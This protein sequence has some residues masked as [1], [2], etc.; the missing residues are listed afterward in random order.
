MCV[1][2]RSGLERFRSQEGALLGVLDRSAELT[3]F[4]PIAYSPEPDGPGAPAAG[5]YRA[6]E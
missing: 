1:W 4:V 6:V 5:A 3:N 2:L